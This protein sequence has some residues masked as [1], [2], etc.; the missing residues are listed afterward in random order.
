[1][2]TRMHEHTQ[3][4]A[5]GGRKSLVHRAGWVPMGSLKKKKKAAPRIG[6]KG[7]AAAAMLV[8]QDEEAGL[9]G[10]KSQNCPVG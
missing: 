5:R 3:G 9:L 2:H 4:W 8:A 1:M 7:Q 6:E 10:I